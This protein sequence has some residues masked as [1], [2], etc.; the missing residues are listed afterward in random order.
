MKIFHVINSLGTGGSESV[1]YTIIKKDKK[2][3]LYFCNI[4]KKVKILKV[5]KKLKI[6]GLLI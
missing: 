3:T 4:W 6:V 5:F 2:Y 1:L